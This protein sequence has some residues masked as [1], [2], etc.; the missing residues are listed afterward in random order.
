[1]IWKYK[2]YGNSDKAAKEK[3]KLHIYMPDRWNN[4]SKVKYDNNLYYKS[5]LLITYLNFIVAF[6]KNFIMSL[7]LNVG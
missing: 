7:Y 3:W 2:M 4:I 6:V 5:K 1:M